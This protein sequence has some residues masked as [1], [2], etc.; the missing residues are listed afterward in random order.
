MSRSIDLGRVVGPQGP[1]GDTGATGPQ[2]PEGPQGKSIP[3]PDDIAAVTVSLGGKFSGRESLKFG[4]SYRTPFAG[5]LSLTIRTNFSEGIKGVT[6]QTSNQSFWDGWA[7]GFPAFPDG[8]NSYLTCHIFFPVPK[9]YKVDIMDLTD[10]TIADWEI[11]SYAYNPTSK[12][13]P[14]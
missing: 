14:A 9:N 2:G 4:S 6:V 11:S 12:F 8:T 13:I 3:N 5:Y 7:A 10:Q 1:K